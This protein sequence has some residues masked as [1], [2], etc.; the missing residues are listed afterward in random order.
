MGTCVAPFA[1]RLSLLNKASNRQELTASQCLVL[2]GITQGLLDAC[3][4]SIRDLHCYR[5]G[6]SSLIHGGEQP[7]LAVVQQVADTGHVALGEVNLFWALRE[8]S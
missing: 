2:I 3:F 5:D 6:N 4:I 1:V 8:N 7:L